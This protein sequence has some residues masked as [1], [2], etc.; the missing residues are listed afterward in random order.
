MDPYTVAVAGLISAVLGGLLGLFSTLVLPLWSLVGYTII[1]DDFRRTRLIDLRLAESGWCTAF[2]VEPIPIPVA[3]THFITFSALLGQPKA[4]HC[5]GV[6]IVRK[7]DETADRNC[8]DQHAV[9]LFC[10]QLLFDRAPSARE[11][12]PV[13]ALA[14]SLDGDPGCVRVRRHEKATPYSHYTSTRFLPVPGKLHNWQWGACRGVVEHYRLHNKAGMILHGPPMCGK[15]SV[16]RFLAAG[17]KKDG[18]SPLVVCGFSF[19]TAG[20]HLQEY[21]GVPTP[22]QPIIL[23][24]NEFDKAV[25]HAEEGKEDGSHASSLAHDRT[26]LLDTLDWLAEVDN[27]IYVVTTN[28]DPEYFADPLDAYI[29]PGR[30]THRHTVTGDG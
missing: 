20:S 17:L 16:A 7:S 26:S 19:K 24:V 15:S 22:E 28:K 5:Q 30:F 18:V 10:P 14:Q 3:G 29:R 11:L 25:A 27:L 13:R 23:L 21:I 12:G 1:F 2:T 4:A 8:F 6:A 9:Y